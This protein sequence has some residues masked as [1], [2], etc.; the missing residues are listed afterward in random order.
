MLL[1]QY[2]ATMDPA[3][4]QK[5]LYSLE[6][7]MVKNVPLIPM[8]G[9]SSYA[10]YRTANAT[11]AYCGKLWP[12]PSMIRWACRAGNLAA[13]D[14]PSVGKTTSSSAPSSVIVGTVMIG[15]AVSLWLIAS[16]A[17]SPANSHARRRR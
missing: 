16:Y 11:G 17:G 6:G 10:E 13:Y 12:A 14:D 5:A 4:Q 15:W 8:F 2:A 9:V 1:A 7:I 3:A